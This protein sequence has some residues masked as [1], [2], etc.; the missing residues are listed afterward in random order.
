VIPGRVRA[1]EVEP[2]IYA[3]DFARLGDQIEA[4][5]EAGAQVF[6]Y[7][8]G[9]GQFVEPITHGPIVIKS[10]APLIEA[11]GGTLDCHLMTIEPERHFAQIARAGGHSVTFHVEASDDP[12]HMVDLARDLDLGVGLALSPETSVE[13][14]VAAA[15]AVDFVLCMCIHPGYSG[16]KFMPEAL[17]RIAALRAALPSEMLVQVDGGIN[18]DN[19]LDVRHAGADLIVAGTSIFG[20]DDVARSYRELAAKLARE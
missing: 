6:H 17:E 18:A 15:D 11:R 20:H 2:S 1:A 16:Q 9:D 10:I 12:A 8:I 13:E 14:A 19:L 3:A 7:D 4:L 5:M